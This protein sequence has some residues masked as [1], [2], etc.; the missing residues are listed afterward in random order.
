MPQYSR[1]ISL[2]SLHL[3]GL[4]HPPSHHLPALTAAALRTTAGNEEFL[5]VRNCRDPQQGGSHSHT[6]RG[7][8]H[9]ASRTKP[10]RMRGVNA[11]LHGSAQARRPLALLAQTGSERVHAYGCD[12]R[13]ALSHDR[14]LGT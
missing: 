3:T 7:G 12:S 9:I 10:L 13:L 14:R 6:E 5:R 2:Q 8:G 4:Y 11:A 1:K